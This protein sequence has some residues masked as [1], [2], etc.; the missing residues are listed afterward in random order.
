MFNFHCYIDVIK[1][2]LLHV[3][4]THPAD[5][6][7]GARKNVFTTS[8]LDVEKTFYFQ[9]YIDIIKICFQDVIKGARFEVFRTSFLNV[10]YMYYCGCY[11]DV[12]KICFKDNPE[13][14]CK[15]ARIKVFITSFP[16]V[17]LYFWGYT[18]VTKLSFQTKLFNIMKTSLKA[19]E[20]TFLRLGHCYLLIA[21]RFRQLLDIQKSWMYVNIAHIFSGSSIFFKQGL[22][23][24]T[25]YQSCIHSTWIFHNRHDFWHNC[26]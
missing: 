4:T 3:I 12:T 7:Q 8:F 9:C 19:L 14:V 26:F 10:V 6:V 18:G 17:T 22:L 11:T 20:W 24:R 5:V 25:S 23:V 13:D 15:G 21:I 16:G 1:I 2:R